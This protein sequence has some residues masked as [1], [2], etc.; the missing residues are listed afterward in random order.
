MNVSD[1]FFLW[2][3]QSFLTISLHGSVMKNS[4]SLALGVSAVALLAA[5]SGGG[6]SGTTPVVNS[7]PMSSSTSAPSPTSAPQ[8]AATLK[9]ANVNGSTAFVTASQQPVYV[10]GAD[11]T[12]ESFCT[13]VG[14]CLGLWPAVLAPSG[15]LSAGFSAFKRS[16]NGELQLAYNGQPLYTFIDDTMPDVATGVGIADPASDGGTGTFTLAVPASA[17]TAAPT[18]APTSAPNPYIAR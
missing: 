12:D 18:S 9:T 7:A 14:N 6:S 11:K 4:I 16:D 17:A 3:I 1:N 2:T 13:S 8:A 15:T 5:C 10:D